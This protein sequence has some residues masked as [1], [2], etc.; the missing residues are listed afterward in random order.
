MRE[1]AVQSANA[2]NSASRPRRAATPKSRSS[3]SEI[4]PRRRADLLQRPEAARRLLHRRQP[5]RSAPTPA[6]PSPSPASPTCRPPRSAAATT[7]VAGPVA[8]TAVTGFANAIVA[9]GLTINGADVG[10]I[11]GAGQR[12]RSAPAR[13][14]RRSTACHRTTNVGASVRRGFAAS[15]PLTSAARDH[16]RRNGGTAADDRPGGGCLRRVDHDHRHQLAERVLVHEQRR[17]PSR[18]STTR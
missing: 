13:S 9:G 5:S 12:R 18:N 3:S 15:S 14:L 1:L 6:R 2:T 7:R 4:E 17:W 10:A 8:A 11:A 16:H